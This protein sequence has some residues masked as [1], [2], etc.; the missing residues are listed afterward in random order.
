MNSFYQILHKQCAET[1]DFYN[2]TMLDHSKESRMKSCE[3]FWNHEMY[4]NDRT[5]VTTKIFIFVHMHSDF[6]TLLSKFQ[7]LDSL[8]KNIFIDANMFEKLL[9]IF[10]KAQRYYS[11]LNRLCYRYKFKKAQVAIQTDIILNPISP[12]QHNVMT[13]LQG[14]KKYFFTVM[15]LKKFIENALCNSPH[16]FSNPLSIKNPYNN[17]PF[18]KS[19]L[20]NIYF[21]MK[22]CDFVL[23][24][25]FHQFF[26]C[27]FHLTRFKNENGVLIRKMHISQH[28]KSASIHELY[29]FTLAMLVEHK[30]CKLLLIDNG[31]PQEELVNIMK[32]YLEL[33][34][35]RLY[36]LDL[37]EKF[38]VKHKL[39][40]LLNAFY[41]FN[42]RFGRKI[43][44]YESIGE[45]LKR[46][47]ITFHKDYCE[48]KKYDYTKDYRNS[49]IELMNI[50]Y[51]ESD[52][53][54]DGES[55]DEYEVNDERR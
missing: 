48:F 19:T 35:T 50:D 44:R 32:P 9:T 2:L 40:N 11:L 12:S 3:V 55:D 22:R 20:Y 42:P 52:G 33:Y 54:S 41:H 39:T 27:N 46:K 53:E 26:L 5:N 47:V 21:F 30:L 25:L 38:D 31:F 17:V 34:Y 45:N 51:Y 15:D 6:C 43:V 18:N 1:S 4:H 28:F 8:R 36:T 14:G 10:S 16:H 37:G 13:I 24:P 23:S 49:H 7:F 29:I